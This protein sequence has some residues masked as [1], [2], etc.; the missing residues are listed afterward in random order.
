[1]VEAERERIKDW[2]IKNQKAT[3]VLVPNSRGHHNIEQ[4]VSVHEA[5]QALTPTPLTNDK[6]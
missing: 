6:E 1:V 3:P 4:L 5:L 2:L